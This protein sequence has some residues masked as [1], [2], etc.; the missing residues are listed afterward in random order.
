MN[1]VGTDPDAV[2]IGDSMA[3]DYIGRT[4]ADAESGE[5]TMVVTLDL[6]EQRAFRQSFPACM[7]A[8]DFELKT[9]E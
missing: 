2:Y 1:R 9:A 6:E 7:D 4:L 8:D 3:V 5:W